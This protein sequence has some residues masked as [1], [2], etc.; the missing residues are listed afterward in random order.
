MSETLAIS[1]LDALQGV[2][3][4]ILQS[5]AETIARLDT[6]EASISKDHGKAVD[7]LAAMRSTAVGYDACLTD[8]DDLIAGVETGTQ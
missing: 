2:R 5:R 6:L 4:K 3:A 8:I 1:A 7:M